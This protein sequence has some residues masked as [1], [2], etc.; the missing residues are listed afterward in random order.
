MKT[1]EQDKSDLTNYGCS[2][3]IVYD[4]NKNEYVEKL[5]DQY[6]NTIDIRTF[7]EEL[8]HST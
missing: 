4:P 7:K 2:I 5:V 6:G 1:I 3:L 8:C